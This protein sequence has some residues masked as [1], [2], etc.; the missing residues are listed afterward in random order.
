MP[1]T[2]MLVLVAT[3]KTG[4]IMKSVDGGASWA[5]IG[6]VGPPGAF[7]NPS[8]TGSSPTVA[9][10]LIVMFVV[11]ALAGLVYYKQR[12]KQVSKM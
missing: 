2:N 4:N 9:I 1:N 5:E 7:S 6:A 11:L 3:L 10:V 8:S 12:D